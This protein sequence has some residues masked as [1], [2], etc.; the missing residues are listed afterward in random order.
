MNFKDRRLNYMTF[1]GWKMKRLNSMNFQVF[2]D[3]CG[4][5]KPNGMFPNE[6]TARDT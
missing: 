5:T 6:I 3:M 2:H 1:Q 4:V